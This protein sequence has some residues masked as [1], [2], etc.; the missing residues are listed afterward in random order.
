MTSP[1]NLS[2]SS[3]VGSSGKTL[4]KLRRI[5]ELPLQASSSGLWHT[6]G[7]KK[8]VLPRGKTIEV[9]CEWTAFGVHFSVAHE[10]QPLT[11]GIKTVG[12]F[13]MRFF[14]P[15]NDSYVVELKGAPEAQPEVPLDVPAAASR[16]QGRA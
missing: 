6:E 7:Y 5:V 9:H 14:F 4:A 13:T 15:D 12:P 3:D 11:A 2:I 1:L 16:R 8:V 10:G